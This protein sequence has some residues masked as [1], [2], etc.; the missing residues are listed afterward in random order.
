[1]RCGSYPVIL[2]AANGTSC[3]YS[4]ARRSARLR[5]AA[6]W[7]AARPKSLPEPSGS[8]SSEE[9]SE[10][11]A[12]VTVPKEMASKTSMTIVPMVTL[13]GHRIVELITMVTAVKTHQQKMMMTITMV[14]LMQAI[15]AKQEILV[16]LLTKRLQTTMK[17][18]VKIQARI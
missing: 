14:S 17:M 9:S 4:C 6:P 7:S 12:S 10:S 5:S 3:G 8:S 13:V 2:L 15:H 11:A 1:M 18:A 16:G